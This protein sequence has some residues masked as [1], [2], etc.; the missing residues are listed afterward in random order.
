MNDV[1]HTAGA[2]RAGVQINAT[3]KE[4]HCL[5]GRTV[6]DELDSKLTN[7]RLLFDAAVQEGC[8]SGLS[9]QCIKMK[10]KH[11]NIGTWNIRTLNEPGKLHLFLLKGLEHLKIDTAGLAET[12]WKGEGHF[13][14]SNDI[15][16]YSGSDVGGQ[17]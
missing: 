12:K 5:P 1:S 3:G 4:L 15:I 2:S 8:S 16:L 10:N 14:S 7:R 13:M 9:I 6:D 17:G 11:L